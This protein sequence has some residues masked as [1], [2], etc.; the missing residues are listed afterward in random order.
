MRKSTKKRIAGLMAA[1]M[2]VTAPVSTPRADGE[3][4]GGG[5]EQVT[6]ATESPEAPSSE[7]PEATSTAAATEEPTTTDAP[8]ET[9]TPTETDVPITTDA[10]EPVETTEPEGTTDATATPS[11]APT[12]APEVSAAE[13]A[14]AKTIASGYKNAIDDATELPI[15]GEATVT[16]TPY[17]TTAEGSDEKT[18][19][20]GYSIF[21]F[22][23]QT[24]A[25][26][27]FCAF[28]ASNTDCPDG[29]TLAV[30]YAGEMLHDS[31]GGM[32]ETAKGGTST[33]VTKLK[34]KSTYYVALAAKN[35]AA[36]SEKQAKLY[37]GKVTD[38]AGDAYSDAATLTLGTTTD[39]QIEGLQDT[40]WFTFT[41]TDS[42]YYTVSVENTDIST[43]TNFCLRD[44]AADGGKVK[45][46]QMDKGKS[47]KETF[48][49]SPNTKYFI[50][51]TT[52]NKYSDVNSGTGSYKINVSAKA[53]DYGDA[54]ATARE[55]TVGLEY[56]GQIQHD[57]DKDY[58]RF[59]SGDLTSYMLTIK[60]TTTASSTT[61]TD[62]ANPAATGAPSPAPTATAPTP[63]TSGTPATA[64][65]NTTAS[66]GAAKDVIT[67]S[68]QSYDGVNSYASGTI[69]AGAT[70]NIRLGDALK[71]FSKNATYC[72]VLS[73]FEDVKYT[74]SV[75]KITHKVEY[76]MNGGTNSTKNPA[77]YTESESLS[78]FEPEERKGYEFEG[79]YTT[80]DFTDGTKITSFD[81]QKSDLK[82]YAK[83]KEVYCTITY[84]LDGGYTD[85]VALY[86]ASF[87]I[88][89]LLDAVKTGYKF[90][91][92][93]TDKT[94]TNRVKE[95][96][97][98]ESTKLTLYAKW[99]I[100]TYKITYN[101]NKGKAPSGNPKEYNVLSKN[102]TF[103]SPTK[104]GYT[105]SGWYSD[106]SYKTKI[107][108]LKAG[109]TGDRTLYA[110]WTKVTTSEPGISKLSVK[111]TKATLK[112]K[113][114]SGAKG[115][116]IQYSL[117]KNFK[118]S[119]TIEKG[120]K[121][122]SLT[123]AKL[124][125]GK[126]YYFRIRAY[127][128][129]SAGKKVYSGWKKKNIKIKK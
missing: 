85:N 12:E 74:F 69:N 126:K 40:D 50:S 76:E 90:E 92:W 79:W 117:K 48:R 4:G 25:T 14:F 1:V 24:G 65:P 103:K 20:D 39:G 6:E 21:W 59:N 127:K 81:G 110:K 112:W 30:F 43:T 63:A 16:F 51:A 83:W 121:V 122:T 67:Y 36:L 9:D 71:P 120:E 119:K 37:Y 13:K 129:D 60:N 89:T 26:N 29:T 7:E 53:D 109:S 3:E 56:S 100:E 45:E 93:Y 116:Q 72:I 19:P 107:T 35:R 31:E 62:T 124:K 52:I 75:Q 128:K 58:F 94:F 55:I 10:P 2:L 18:Y 42:T 17:E 73:G 57:Q 97:I 47:A 77:G 27:D 33:V 82:L 61:S 54:A 46:W 49:L 95:L 105:F 34:K 38:D 88:G 78:L 123:V 118:K 68:V 80:K 87:P 32:M 104:A 86:S 108:G 15:G 99:S 125:K 91:G 102:I 66:T 114:V 96:T 113:K 11:E 84:E 115:Y 22:K 8:A 28:R 98:P 44:F 111:K 5:S 70:G 64:S 101:L 41:T 106:S 23:V